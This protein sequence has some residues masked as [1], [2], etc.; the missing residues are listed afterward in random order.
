MAD[1]DSP[2]T[3]EDLEAVLN[4]GMRLLSRQ[5]IKIITAEPMKDS[6]DKINSDASFANTLKAKYNALIEAGFSE[7]Q[8]FDLA[9]KAVEETLK[10]AT[11]QTDDKDT[12]HGNG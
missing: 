9:L 6:K 8:A 1:R 10:Q 4:L 11:G 2:F 12:D 3:K 5:L 7:K